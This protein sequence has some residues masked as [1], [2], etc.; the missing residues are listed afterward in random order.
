MK[1]L[2]EVESRKEA[3]QIRDGLEDPAVRAFVKVT[4]VLLKLKTDRARARVM[5]FVRDH[6]EEASS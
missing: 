2:I 1:A 6:F 3:Q 4:G 5:S